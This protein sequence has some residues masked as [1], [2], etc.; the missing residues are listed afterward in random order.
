MHAIH[1]GARHIG[2]REV[3]VFQRSARQHG[4]VKRAVMQLAADQHRALHEAGNEFAAIEVAFFHRYVFHIGFGKI[5]FL[6]GHFIQIRAKHVRLGEQ[7]GVH[8]RAVESG[9]KQI[10]F[11]EVCAAKPAIHQKSPFEIGFF[12]TCAGEITLLE[13]AVLEIDA[14]Q[15]AA[16]QIQ[17]GQGFSGK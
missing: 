16:L 11:A 15:P 14:I 3:A 5:G 17:F 10:G 8:L 7:A 13:L 12:E 1:Q 4:G 9:V 6:G 2:A